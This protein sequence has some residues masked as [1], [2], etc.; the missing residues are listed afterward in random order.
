MTMVWIRISTMPIS[1]TMV[2]ISSIHLSSSR[3]KLNNPQV[4]WWRMS[5]IWPSVTV[6]TMSPNAVWLLCRQE[7]L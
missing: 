4:H 6:L 7:R 1:V 5:L 3:P 2:S